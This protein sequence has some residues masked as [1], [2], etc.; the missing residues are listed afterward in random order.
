MSQGKPILAML[1]GDTAKLI[2]EAMCGFSVAV[3]KLTD[4]VE[5]IMRYSIMPEKDLNKMGL[6]GQM[7]YAEHF[8]KHLRIEQLE[9]LF[10]ECLAN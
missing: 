5:A 2:E 9:K 8:K 6:N 1:N 10:L 7:Y 4:L 3:N